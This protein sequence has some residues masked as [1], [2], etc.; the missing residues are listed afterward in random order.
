MRRTRAETDES[1]GR[2]TRRAALLGG[3]QLLFMGGLAARMRYLQVEQADQY[4]LLAEENRINVRLIPPSR[5]EVF[6]RNGKR[7]AQNAPSYRIVIVRED[8]GDVDASLARL[9]QIVDLEDGTIER[10][11][12]EIRRSAPF[13]PVTIVSDVTWEDISRVSVNAPALNNL[14]I[15]NFTIWWRG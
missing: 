5:G 15:K 2:L 13:L 11:Q 12:Q 3:V 4:R 10:V 1:Y 6:D 9:A 8:A 14:N 7:L